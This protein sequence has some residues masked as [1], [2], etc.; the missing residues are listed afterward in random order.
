[1]ADKSA[2]IQV[3]EDIKAGMS[4][5]ACARK[6][7]LTQQTVSEWLAE[8]ALF[9][10]QHELG[11]RTQPLRPDDAAEA[12]RIVRD[13]RAQVD[14]IRG[15]IDTSID[16]PRA[17]DNYARAAAALSQ[18]MVRLVESHPGLMQLS[19]LDGTES[20]AAAVARVDA[21]LDRSTR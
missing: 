8:A 17:V 14:V 20:Q 4:Q 21:F 6:H 12:L 19:G 13:I 11:D 1:M 10:C 2:R 18:T 7:G 16:N 9:M 5:T 3:F 15:K